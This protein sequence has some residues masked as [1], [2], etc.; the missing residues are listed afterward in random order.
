MN[1]FEDITQGIDADTTLSLTFRQA[2]EKYIENVKI[3]APSI[4]KRQADEEALAHAQGRKLY[5]HLMIV[6]DLMPTDD[7]KKEFVLAMVWREI[8]KEGKTLTEAIQS[9]HDKVHAGYGEINYNAE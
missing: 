5:S 2:V 8:D 1:G 3:Q 4:R 7:D 6:D 9:I